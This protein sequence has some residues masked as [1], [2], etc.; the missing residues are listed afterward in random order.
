MS[1]LYSARKIMNYRSLSEVIKKVYAELSNLDT[2]VSA[3][4]G[5]GEIELTMLENSGSAADII[6]ANGSKVP[7]YVAMSGDATISNAGAVTIAND[8]VDAAQINYFLSTEQT[9][10]GSEQS[11]A[12]GL[13]S[14]PTA[15]LVIPS[16]VADSANTFVQGTH[17]STNVLVTATNTSKYYVFAVK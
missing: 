6:V 7:T 10:N 9:G 5:A 16:G 14:T 2:R 17:T 4:D 8:A 13:G 1:L 12:H 15:V 3:L 11:V